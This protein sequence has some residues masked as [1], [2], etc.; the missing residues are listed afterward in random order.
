MSSGESEKCAR[1]S[2]ARGK[3]DPEIVACGGDVV[4]ARVSE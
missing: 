1:T 3:D 2:L 4:A